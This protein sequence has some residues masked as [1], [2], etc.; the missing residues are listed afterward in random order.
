MASATLRGSTPAAVPVRTAL[1]S[2]PGATGGSTDSGEVPHGGHPMNAAGTV[3]VARSGGL[4]RVVRPTPV[5]ANSTPAAGGTTF[6]GALNFAGQPKAPAQ[7]PTVYSDEQQAIIAC[8]ARLVVADA[9]AGCGKTTTAVG[10]CEARPHQRILYLVLNAA[11]AAEAKARFPSN[12]S[13]MTTHSLAWN[14]PGMRRHIGERLDRRWRAMTLMQQFRISTPADAYNAQQVLQN[15]FGSVDREIGDKHVEPLRTARN[16]TSNAAMNAVANAR[17]IW[18]KICDPSERCSIPDDA[19]LKMFALQAPQ[20]PYDQIIM[21]EAQD[22]NPVTAQIIAA[23]LKARLLC[24]GDRHQAIYQFR[25]SVNAME[26]FSVGADRFHITQTYRFGPRI[27]AVANLILGE[28]KGE[29]HKIVGMAAD[30]AWNPRR[31][32]HL[33][34][35]NAQLFSLAAERRGEGMYWVGK[36]GKDGYQVGR[37]GPDNYRLSL[38]ADVYHLYSRERSLVQ[39]RSLKEVSSF[40]DYK[41]YAE[42]AND[43]EARI[44]TKLVE[45]H[46]SDTL[47]LIEDIRSNAVRSEADAEIVLTTAHKSKG[48]EWDCVRLCEDFEFLDELEV[49][50]A[51]DPDPKIPVQDINLLYVAATRAK[52]AL[53]LNKETTGWL[54]ELPG[55]R[56]NRRLNRARHEYPR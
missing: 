23:Q 36:V 14:S 46:G 20:L 7:K 35:T 48:L 26:R 22:A 21:D 28:L 34:R 29:A 49:D 30:G 40:D 15:F 19:Y 4:G 5:T 41:R 17:L 51:N 45:E 24:I 1:A 39:D 10:F 42:D 8:P 16:I 11:N 56:E 44:M 25:G 47:A 43:G 12:V 2:M 13:A 52:A 18:K 53:E 50:L 55:H 9:F 33:S 32:T 3:T 31:V 6:A 38:L 27:A 54:Q 37:D